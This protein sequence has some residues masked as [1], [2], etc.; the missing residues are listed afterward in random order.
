MG[1]INQLP[2][3]NDTP[4]YSDKIEGSEFPLE[5]QLLFTSSIQK[6]L[7]LSFSF[8]QNESQQIF[9]DILDR[10]SNG[11]CTVQDRCV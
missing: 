10:V 4:L 3:V 1:D 11:E 6:Y 9:R 2:P 7:F 8:R 5:G